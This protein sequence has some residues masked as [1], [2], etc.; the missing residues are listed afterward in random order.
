MRDL[1]VTEFATTD[2]NN[3]IWH[4]LI[5]ETNV[6]LSLFDVYDD[7]LTTLLE[8]I[9]SSLNK[10]VAKVVM[11]VTSKEKLILDFLSSLSERIG[12]ALEPVLSSTCMCLSYGFYDDCVRKSLLLLDF[13][14]ESTRV[15][16]IDHSNNTYCF[17]PSCSCD[18]LSGRALFTGLCEAIDDQMSKEN[19][20]L[21]KSNYAFQNKKQINAYQCLN[22]TKNIIMLQKADKVY[23][24]KDYQVHV[25]IS[26]SLFK[27]VALSAIEAFNSALRG[28]LDESSIPIDSF[29]D[30][31][32]SGGVA[33]CNYVYDYIR[34]T[35][36]NTFFPD[37]LT[38]YNPNN[39][40]NESVIV[41]GAAVQCAAWMGYSMKDLQSLLFIDLLP[42]DIFIKTETGYEIVIPKGASVP[43]RRTVEFVLTEE[44]QTS[45]SV[46]IFRNASTSD[47]YVKIGEFEFT[48]NPEELPD[49][50]VGITIT[51]AENGGISAECTGAYEPEVNIMNV[52]ILSLA[53]LVL[54][55]AYLFLKFYFRETRLLLGENRSLF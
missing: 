1:G 30:V 45:L 34:S 27:R 50:S 25:G 3:S 18:S 7:F 42:H 46:E 38:I 33:N 8:K 54:V 44:N 4:I 11:V 2:A 26:S 21:L 40:A 41:N 52:I 22:H 55:I 37:L 47:D 12:V 49:S 36:R 9:E 23:R 24:L 10:N 39:N 6:K 15:Q 20:Q 5:G 19:R 29:D 17:G 53:L 31:L 48:L 51:V 28:F 13:G 43:S 32:I 14:W 16:V 35:F